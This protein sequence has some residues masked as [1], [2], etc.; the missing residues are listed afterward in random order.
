MLPSIITNRLAAWVRG[1]HSTGIPVRQ[2]K[3]RRSGPRLV[4]ETLETRAMPV[5]GLTTFAPGAYVID[6]GQATQTVA[7]SLKPYGMVYDLVQN[8][9]IPI[10]WAINP[11]RPD[12][13]PHN[14]SVR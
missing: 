9:H 14:E 3:R 12:S 4:L 11:N 2:D 8:K 7:N 10:D 1:Y 5:T 13:F 6:M